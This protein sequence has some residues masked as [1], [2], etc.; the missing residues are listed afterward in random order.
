VSTSLHIFLTLVLPYLGPESGLVEDI[1][2][3]SSEEMTWS[4]LLLGLL[5]KFSFGKNSS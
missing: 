1:F 2:V 4:K 5:A 3:W